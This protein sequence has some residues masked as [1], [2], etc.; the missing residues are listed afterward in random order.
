MVFGRRARFSVLLLPLCLVGCPSRWRKHYESDLEGDLSDYPL[1]DA[2]C[3]DEP[4]IIYVEDEDYIAKMLARGY[5]PIGSSS[6]ETTMIADYGN[7]GR[8]GRDVCADRVTIAAGIAG[9]YSGTV[10]LPGAPQT[11]SVTSSYFARGSGGWASG[12]GTAQITTP[13]ASVAVPYTV[14]KYGYTAI[15]WVKGA[16]V[17][18]VLASPIKRADRIR[19]GLVAGLVV[20]IVIRD[21]GAYDADL[22]EGDII[23]SCAGDPMKTL[24]NLEACEMSHAGERVKVGFVRDGEAHTVKVEFGDGTPAF[25]KLIAEFRRADRERDATTHEDRE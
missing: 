25:R 1:L 9:S 4:S 2:D 13:G 7:A 10:Y 6:F 14:T 18:G 15:Y 16:S 24:G 11:A 3:S 8:V 12:T 19:Q 20:D 22:L 17:L 5:Y 21:T 23:T